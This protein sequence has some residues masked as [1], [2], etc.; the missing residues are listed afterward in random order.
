MPGRH[1][2]PRRSLRHRITSLLRPD[3]EHPAPERAPKDA[4]AL[5]R[6]MEA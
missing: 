2:A 1:R 4:E 6:L 3:N 5:L